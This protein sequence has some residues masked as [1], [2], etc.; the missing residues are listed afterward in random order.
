MIGTACN[1]RD[2][3]ENKECREPGTRRMSRH[4]MSVA[5]ETRTV[6]T[7]VVVNRIERLVHTTLQRPTRE[8]AEPDA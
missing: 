2:E 4:E 6:N 8:S 1:V 7:A 5:S 3:D